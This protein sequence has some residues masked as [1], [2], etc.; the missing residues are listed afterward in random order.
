LH[1]VDDLGNAAHVRTDQ[2]A[3]EILGT[4]FYLG[5]LTGKNFGV[6]LETGIALALKPNTRVVLFSQDPISDLHFDLKPTHV[7]SYSLDDL[8]DKSAQALIEAAINFEEETDAYV[9]FVTASLTSDAVIV[10]GF[11]RVL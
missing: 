2:I 8:M 10:L 1:R 5:D 7:N 4:H 9:R 3:E 6:I 11:F